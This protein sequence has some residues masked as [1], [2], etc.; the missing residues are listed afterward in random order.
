[1]FDH[2]EGAERAYAGVRDRVGDA[3]WMH[4]IAFVEHHKRG[5]IVVRGVFAGHYVDTE[6]EADPIGKDAGVGA[7]TGAVVG[8]AFGPP[9]F[10]AGLVGGGAV[11]GLIEGSHVE[12]LH[13][14]FF[15][16]VRADVPVGASALVLLA[17]P[18]HADAMVAALEGTGAR[19]VRRTLSDSAV[20]HL[21]ESVATA[22][23]ASAPPQVG[24]WPD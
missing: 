20:A 2:T 19:V 3:P 12:E 21:A 10:A 18:D 7:L 4:E 1:L 22:P 16:T 23:P 5:R 11:G 8:A 24:E 15:D 9:G 6:D 17:A 14:G 13:G